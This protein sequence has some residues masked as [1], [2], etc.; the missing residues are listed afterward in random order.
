MRKQATFTEVLLW[1]ELRRSRLG[2]RFR[3]QEPI[4]PFIADF[5][6]MSHRLVVEVD[7]HDMHSREDDIARDRWFSDHGWFVIRLDNR[8]VLSDIEGAVHLVRL[9][10]SDPASVPDPLNLDFRGLDPDTH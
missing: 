4:G 10:L 9:A 2:V 6:C 3:R 8:Q 1:Q 7:G 5:A